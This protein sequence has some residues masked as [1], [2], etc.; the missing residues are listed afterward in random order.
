M[1]RH[2]I[3][4]S[5]LID[6]PARRLYSIIADYR[7]GH[8][9]ILPRPPFVSMEVTGGGFG[10]GT[11]IDL[12]MRILGTTRTYHGIVSEPDPGR[13][14][15][16]H[17][18]GADIVTTFTVDPRDGG[19]SADV[20]ISTVTDVGRGLAGVVERWVATRVLQPV[21]M[22]ELDRLAAVAADVSSA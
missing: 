13:V 14:I 8:P 11:Q 16:E 4:A 10:T 20:T 1:A 7:H 15:S 12:V 2:C 5:M 21:Y 18:V 19:R 17:Y 6:A 9:R 3:S 22:K